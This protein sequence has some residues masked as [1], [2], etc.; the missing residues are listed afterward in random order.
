[1]NLGIEGELPQYLEAEGQAGQLRLRFCYFL[2][3]KCPSRD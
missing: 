2:S 1:M 3:S